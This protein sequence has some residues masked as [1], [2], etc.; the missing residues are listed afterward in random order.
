MKKRFKI[1]LACLLSVGAVSCS[2]F[3]VEEMRNQ[4]QVVPVEE[5]IMKMNQKVSCLYGRTKA[6]SGYTVDVITS[7][8]LQ[9]GTKSGGEKMNLPDTLLYVVNFQNDAGF[10]LLSASRELKEDTFC[11]TE[12]GNMSVEALKDA[13]YD[14][15]DAVDDNV[16]VNKNEGSYHHYY[17]DFRMVTYGSFPSSPILE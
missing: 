14:M 13:F 6:S 7:S 5:A 2:Q 3:N 16:D 1:I 15:R 8:D 12:Q 11:I 9:C 10:A 4:S 17:K